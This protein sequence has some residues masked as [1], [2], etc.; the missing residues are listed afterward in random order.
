MH[1]QDNY[2]R[3]CYKCM[4]F[5][6]ASVASDVRVTSAPMLR[7]HPW[8]RNVKDKTRPHYQRMHVA[9][10]FMVQDSL[11]YQGSQRSSAAR[12]VLSILPCVLPVHPCCD[13]IHGL[14]MILQCVPCASSASFASPESLASRLASSTSFIPYVPPRGILRPRP[15]G[16]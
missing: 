9:T 7:L 1:G 6:Y 4:H 10:A 2:M 15:P 13:C 3:S 12:T 5:G 8:P 16:Q 14:Y 11:R